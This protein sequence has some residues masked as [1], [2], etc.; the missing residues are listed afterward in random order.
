MAAFPSLGGLGRPPSSAVIAPTTSPLVRPQE[1]SPSS[2]AL[3]VVLMS[4]PDVSDLAH[5]GGTSW[6]R[7]IVHRVREDSFTRSS[8]AMMSTTIINSIIGYAFWIVSARNFDASTIG[9]VSALVSAA[10][11]AATLADLGLRTMVM[12]QLPTERSRK[13]WSSRVSGALVLGLVSSFIFG[14]LAWLLA[15]R[16]SHQLAAFV[17]P[18]A[19]VCV[20]LLTVC[21]TLYTML[22]GI[23]VAEHRAGQIVVRNVLYGTVKVVVLGGLLLLAF[24]SPQLALIATVIG[25]AAPTIFGIVW[26]LRSARPDWR[27]SVRGTIEPLRE[28]S[29]KLVGHHIL[30]IGGWLPGFVMPLEVVALSTTQ[31]NAYMTLTW[32]LGNAFFTVSPSVSSA[33]FV[34]GR[35]NPEHLRKA[36]IK[37]TKLIAVLLVPVGLI[38]AAAG[39]FILGFFGPAYAHYGYPLL[40]V[41]LISAIPDAITNVRVGRLRAQGR[42]ATGAR[43]NAGM[44]IVSIGLAWI[45]IP[46]VG[47]VGVGIAWLIAQ[48]TGSIWGLIEDRFL[49]T[50][51]RSAPKHRWRRQQA[52]HGRQETDTEVGTMATVAENQR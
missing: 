8:L 12:Q 1:M 23:S 52:R 51:T 6:I 2:W 38:L 44:A 43:L 20:L 28:V 19:G 40:L 14:L 48:T 9:A 39:H 31:Q 5:T 32:M 25:I 18:V 15:P 24:R 33:L 26:Q 17:N 34:Q 4:A 45:L 11:I 30:N 27:F 35:W 36:T 29:G 37:A 49:V 21:L 42:L 7:N 50:K 47:I 16:L 41:L 13:A 3:K 46:H 10:T 22:D